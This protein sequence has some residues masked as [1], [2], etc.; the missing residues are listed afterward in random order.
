M[1]RWAK[2]IEVA[3]EYTFYDLPYHFAKKAQHG[4]P[5]KEHEHF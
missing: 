2:W 1:E 5:T 4:F 3:D